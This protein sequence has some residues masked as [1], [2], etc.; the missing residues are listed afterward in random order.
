M[1]LRNQVWMLLCSFLCFIIGTV[2]FCMADQ[3]NFLIGAG[4]YDI[5][6]PAAE[7]GMM[8]YSMPDQKTSGI[9]TRLRSRAYVISE[10]N[11]GKR[12]A[13]VSADLQAIFQAVKQQVVEKLQND[14][15]LGGLYTESNVLLSANHTHSGPGGYS[16]YT[17]YD[18]S[19]LGFI[20]ENFNAIVNGIYQ[21]IKI[22]HNNLTPGKILIAQGELDDCGWQRSYDAYMNNPQ[23]ERDQYSSN[24]DKTMTLLKLVSDQNEEIG[25]INWFAVHTTSIGNTNKLI[26]S[27]NKGYAE[28]LF[29]KVKGTNY[30]TE[31]Q[32]TFVGAFAQTNAGDV[33]PNIYW[34]YPDG[35]HDFDHMKIIGERQYNKAFS[36]Y[37]N[38]SEYLEG[39]VEYRHKHVNFDEYPI[40]PQWVNGHTGIQTCSAAIGFSQVA[41]STEDGAGIDL[42][43][44]GMVWGGN[45]WPE[46]TLVPDL[47]ECQE[48]KII[49]LPA[50]DMQP[51]PWVPEVLPLQIVKIGNLAIVAAPVEVTTMAGRRI[52]NTVI[53]ELGSDV[54]YVVIAAISNAYCSYLTTR[55]EYEIQH[56][57][58]GSNMF[59]PYSL[60]AFQQE[61]ALLAEALRNGTEVDPGPTPRDLRNDVINFQ[62]GV[63]WDGKY[64]NQKFGDVEVD[65]NASYSRGSTVTVQFVGGHPKN[66]LMIQQT[67]LKIEKMKIGTIRVCHDEQVGCDTIEVCKNV[68]GPVFDKVVANDWDPETVYEWQR[69]GMDRSNVII[70]WTIPADAEPGQY[71]I[72][73]LGHW[74]N[75]WDGSINPYEG[76]SRV[77]TVQ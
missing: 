19:V 76:L 77:F 3:G 49:L 25:M 57:E 12:I 17:T 52:R 33:S 43:H 8:G 47:Q 58:G 4:V 51:Y 73:H 9:H 44:E 39:G 59:G 61:Y 55:E 72:R 22:A 2:S 62:T 50:G 7:V 65:A 41:G 53:A 66:N 11:G 32:N 48:E 69:E 18:L 1:R 14:P 68:P 27:D 74:K 29:E 31:N 56:Y 20:E 38:A 45:D 54:D 37:N 36:L 6:G 35:I 21:S 60:N 26:S 23:T 16:H 15:A 30:S 13:F 71:R 63:V 75:G 24:T 70:K 46:F 42:A 67:F 28:Y 5:T 64:L 34:G 40:D 10:P